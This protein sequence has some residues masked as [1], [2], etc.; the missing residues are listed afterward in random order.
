MNRLANETSP[1]LRQHADNP[2]DWYAW[3][4]EALS[5][6]KT[7][8]KPI[9][10]SVGYSA[11]HWCHVMAHE[12]FEDETTAA[13]MNKL[14]VNIKVDREE[15]P[16]IDDIYMQAVQ[17][18]SNGHGGWPMTVFLL[19]D[20]RPFYAG[21]YFPKEARYGMPS[22]KQVLEGVYDA[23][24]N[25]RDEVEEI[26]GQLTQGLNRASLGIGQGSQ[27]N[28]DLLDATLKPFER[29]YDATY[30]GFGGAPKFPQAMN[31][32][33][34]LQYHHRTGDE[35]ALNMVTLTLKKMAMGGIYDQ[36]GGGFHRYSVDAIWLV[37]HFEK[38]LYDN[39]LLSRVYLHAWQ[40]TGD[41]FFKETAEEIYDYILREM[42]APEGG[43]YSAT[44]A[45][46]EG[47]EGKFF[48]WSKDE[49]TA[50]LGEENGRIAVETWGVSGRGNFEGHN[51]LYRPN[52]DA[53]TAARLGLTVEQ[54]REKLE[55]IKDILFAA[56]A[57]R[58]HPG[59]DD[60]ILASWNGLMLASLAEAARV[61]ER[62]DY[63]DG[64]LR[65]GQ[66]LREIMVT[67][68]GR[69]FRTYKDGSARINGF[70]EDYACLAEAFL[71][72]YQTTF[73]PHWYV[74][75]QTLADNALKHFR[76]PDGGFFDTPDDGET[77]IARP[78]S[79]Q[80][81]AVPAGSSIMAKVLVM[82]AAYSGSADYEQAARETLAP[83]DAAMRQVPQAFGEALAAAGMLVR[84]MR[85]IAVVGEFNDD[86][87]VALLTE[88]FDDYRPNAVVA[89]SPSDVD[90]E[91]TIPLLSYRVMQEGEPTVYVC[92]QFACQLPVTTPDALQSLLD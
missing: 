46:S 81:N 62:Q 13:L 21:T 61:L 52:D 49:L 39:A 5:R 59:L 22:F 47:V 3:G 16:D 41:T 60:K 27:L 65:A 77:L 6:A 23:Y 32:E 10:L 36:L 14:Y 54:L 38:M 84:G 80:D 31:L 45:D 19:P 17:A 69:V 50:L 76:A 56:R 25:R 73:D 90:G 57:Q 34:L 82:L 51:I 11:C 24:Q 8:N 2:V 86:R 30:G 74:L 29:E 89:L 67:S 43:F 79:L 20:G 28:E 85:E 9:L 42:T 70:L 35:A 1:Y 33:Y 68:A 53:V 12:S 40:V 91:H 18:L 66:F 75:A 92:R 88:I 37:P 48:V 26:A 87:T 7:E 44:D 4:E 72:L 64:A 83:L 63:L 15:R 71:Q 78:R 58:V 55:I